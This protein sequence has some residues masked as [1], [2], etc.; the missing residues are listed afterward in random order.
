MLKHKKTIGLISALAVTGA[1]SA[2]AIAQAATLHHP[3]SA[4][5][6]SAE[7]QKDIDA[8]VKDLQDVGATQTQINEV[9]ELLTAKA[10]SAAPGVAPFGLV[11]NGIA[12]G[13]ALNNPIS[14]GDGTAIAIFPGS[15]A[16]TSAFKKGDSAFALAIF[17]LA[18]ATTPDHL[19]GAFGNDGNADCFGV[20]TIANSSTAGTCANIAGTFDFRYDKPGQDVQF[21]LTNPL[22]IITDGPDFGKI[23]TELIINGDINSALTEDVARLSFSTDLSNPGVKLTSDYGFNKILVKEGNVLSPS[24]YL[25]GAILI[26]WM[27]SEILLFPVT[28]V[29]GTKTVNYLGLPQVKFGAPAGIADVLPGVTIG[30]FKLPL[31]GDIPQWSV[32]NDPA[33]SGFPQSSSGGLLPR[34]AFDSGVTALAEPSEDSSNLLA[35]DPSV[36]VPEATVEPAAP[37]DPPVDTVTP[38]EPV[39]DPV[40]ESVLPE[41]VE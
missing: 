40:I 4:S 14:L 8:F 32:N 11:G 37:V 10:A 39:Q 34:A 23:L 27:G 12:G 1:M 35:E 24:K 25:D 20:F 17:G 3:A 26:N 6:I 19:T 41:T 21:A 36:T 7:Q 31:I 18:A 38:V 5:T 28:T 22:A 2:P 15:F 30:S 13:V 16:G 33:E 9:T 29:N